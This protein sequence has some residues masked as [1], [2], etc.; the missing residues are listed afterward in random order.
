MRFIHTADWHLGKSLRGHPLIDD[1][2]YILREFLR[3]IKDVKP[4][5]IIMAGDVYDRA[6]PPVE[7]TELLNEVLT[8]IVLEEKVKVLMIAG[9]HDSGGRL[10]FGNA[11]FER[12]GLFVRGT[13]DRELK[14]VVLNDE[15]GEIY[16]SLIPYFDPT[17][18]QH[19]FNISERPTFDEAN[20]AAVTAARKHIPQGKR[21]VAAAHLFMV[22][23]VSGES[24]RSLA[25]GGAGNV[26]PQWFADFNYT[27]LGHLHAPQRVGADK[28]R[29]SGSLLKYSFDEVNQKKGVLTVNMDEKGAVAA[30]FVP[31][32]PRRD[33]C[34]VEGQIEDIRADR[35]K[36]PVSDD[37]VFVRLT[38][39]AAVI[40]AYDKLAAVY[41]NLCGIDFVGI[42]YNENIIDSE[43]MRQDLSEK[44]LFADFYREVTGQVLSDDQ[45]NIL[46]ECIEKVYRD[47][48][49][50]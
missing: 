19:I 26:S 31:L 50:G 22:G 23:G 18:A 27:A 47:E 48:R 25:V 46:K 38:D 10:D 3:L 34:I 45:E 6:L 2:E 49:T 17:E 12:S 44:E 28:I 40:N 32:T 11:L 5:A 39:T 37:Y 41:K 15:Y 20:F 21:S 13:A 1:Q 7:A 24:E 43:N 29:Y 42:D 30:E 36:Y 4:D 16:F 14:P 35:A 8:K 9:N 33:L